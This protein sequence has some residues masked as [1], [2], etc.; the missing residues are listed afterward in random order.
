MSADASR[1]SRGSSVLIG[2]VAELDAANAVVAE[3]E[4]GRAGGLL[5][6]GAPGIGKT[7]LLREAAA[8]AAVRGVRVARSSCLPLMTTLPF[9]PV[10]EL[11]RS[12]G[13]PLP[14]AATESPHELFGMVLD[15]LERAT[16]D[17]PL[18]L[19][20]DDLQW[21]D[22]G[23]IDL[24][25]YCLARLVDLPI[26]WLMAARPAAEVERVAHRLV[27]AG[28]LEQ[29]ELVALTLEAVRELAAALL[30]E[31]RV[32]DALASLLYARTGGNPFLCEELLQAL[33]DVTDPADYS[34]DAL[35]ELDR[36]V[37]RSVTDAIEERVSRLPASARE[38]LDWA[39]VLPEPF[40]FGELQAV[41]GEESASTPESLAAASFLAADGAE[42]WRFVHSIA[43]DAVYQRLSERERVR[44]HAAVADALLDAPVERRAPQLASAR[45]WGEAAAAYLQLAS[46]A[47]NRGKGMDAVELY[48]RSGGLARKGGDDRLGRDAQ[49]G[50]VLALVRA[51]E[52]DQAARMASVVRP[53]LRV[54][55]EHNECLRFLSRYA[56]ALIDDARDLEQAREVLSEA[57]P[58]ITRAAGQVLAE[59]LAVRAFVRIREIDSAA[60]LA[61]AERAVDVAE[62]AGNPAVLARALNSLGIVVGVARD[63]RRGMAILERGL[64]VAHSADLPALEGRARLSLSYLAGSTGDVEAWE[65]HSSRGLAVDGVPAQLAAMLRGNLGGARAGLGDLDGALAHS[66]TALR[67]A[68]RIGPQAEAS[69]AIDLA[70]VYLLRGDLLAVRRL[71]GD[72]AAACDAVDAQSAAAIG[73][74]LLEQEGAPAQALARFRE[75]AANED[76]S[77]SLWCLTGL[78]RS[79]VAA[80]NLT[81]AR[82]ALARLERIAN[83]SLVGE[84]LREEAVGWVAVGENRPADAATHFRAASTLCSVAYDATRLALETA[85]LQRDRDQVRAAID[86][87]ERM[88]AARA[89]DRARA[90]AR[91]LGMR[92]GRRR[93]PAG[94]LTARE[95]E[96]AHMVAGGQTNAE[97]A[98]TLYLSPRTVEHYVSSILAKLGYR[99]RVQV[100]SEAAAGRLPRGRH[101]T[102]SET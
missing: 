59:A 37:P 36:L 13:E 91:S 66:L 70:Y 52:M 49:A 99:S 34:G 77:T 81:V 9:D 29:L 33:E 22:A 54:Q 39:A 93:A 20:L 41:A 35:G 101:P 25:H 58:L 56:I 44:R 85:R 100:A 3:A 76:D 84:W 50:E 69:A 92:P 60:A 46:A 26:A 5:L 51:G 61:D 64:A 74:E 42:G 17:S 97:I 75:G 98:A 8:D 83:R 94:R 4:Q 78:V 31:D 21:S 1:A 12:L 89:A 16:V 96:I 28:V 43:R 102:S 67:E 32:S 82:D 7:R 62:A 2:R 55:G 53:L 47:L 73:G 14:A 90:V 79:A 11:L 95:Q 86:R 19:C 63:A 88:G 72:H 57:E 68:A 45:R 48:Q 71:L 23:T 27:R 15:R 10:L 87:F 65:A 6:R 40:T 18:L 30:G 80:G 38:A 24:V